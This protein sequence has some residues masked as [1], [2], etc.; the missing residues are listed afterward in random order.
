MRSIWKVSDAEV[1]SAIHYLDPDLLKDTN[2]HHEARVHPRRWL[3][4][5]MVI[6]SIAAFLYF[7]AFRYWPAL[8]RLLS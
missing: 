3:K 8:V 7:T 5:S 6:L 2:E 1:L 4:I